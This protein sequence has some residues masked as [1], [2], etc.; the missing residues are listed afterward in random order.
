LKAKYKKHRFGD[1]IP[2]ECIFKHYEK[3]LRVVQRYF[4]YEGRFERVYRY[5]IRLLMNFIGKKLLNFPLSLYKI[6][7]KMSYIVQARVD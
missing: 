5:H 4:T 7:G 1:T 2:R 6:L 3:F